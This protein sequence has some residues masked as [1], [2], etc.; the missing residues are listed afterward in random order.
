MN[1]VYKPWRSAKLRNSINI[2]S[3]NITHSLTLLLIEVLA[4]LKNTSQKKKNIH[5]K[6]AIMLVWFGSKAQEKR[7]KQALVS[8]IHRV[9]IEW[10][11]PYKESYTVN[12]H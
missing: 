12:S 3:I 1:R 2:S 11:S 6:K 7:N 9:S 8:N 5:N 4:D 10:K